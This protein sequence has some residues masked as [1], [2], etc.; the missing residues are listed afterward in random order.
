MLASSSPRPLS[1]AYPGPPPPSS[2]YLLAQQR[3]G[4]GSLRHAQL[5]GAV[6]RTLARAHHQHCPA[7]GYGCVGEGVRMHLQA[8]VCGFI[9]S[10]SSSFL[11]VMLTFWTSMFFDPADRTA[12]AALQG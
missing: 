7:P 12:P 1:L 8:W 10:F 11:A 6:Q 5:V 4:A 3:Q 2:P 9:S